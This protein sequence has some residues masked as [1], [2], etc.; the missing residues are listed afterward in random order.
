MTTAPTTMTTAPITSDLDRVLFEEAPVGLA[1]LDR[2]LR[3]VRVNRRLAD[4]NGRTVEEMLGRRVSDVFPDVSE[5]VLDAFERVLQTGAVIEGLEVETLRGDPPRG[6]TFVAGYRPVAD[7]DEIIGVAVSSIEITAQK[8]AEDEARRSRDVADLLAAL[9]ASLAAATS[10]V[11]AARHVVD[12]TGPAFGAMTAGFFLLDA[13]S[14]LRSIA[15]RGYGDGILAGSGAWPH[16]APSPGAAAMRAG[17]LLAWPTLEAVEADFPEIAAAMRERTGERAVASVPLLVD[18]E[19][20]GALHVGFDARRELSREE[21]G[22]LRAIADVTAQAIRRI[23]LTDAERRS[24]RVLEAV[25]DQMPLG[26]ILAGAHGELAIMNAESR[27][28]WGGFQPASSVFDQAG[29]RAFHPDGT[30]YEPEDWPLARS[31]TTGEVITD[32]DIEIETF[33]GRRRVLE[34]AS[35]PIRDDDGSILGAVVVFTDVTEKREASALRDAFIGMLSHELRT[36]ITSIY[37]VANLLEA[38]GATMDPETRSGL[39]EDMRAESDRLFRLVE[40]LLVLARAER[41]VTT[42]DA[43][44]VLVHRLIPRIVESEAA[45]WPALRIRFT[46]PD[47]LPPA[48]ADEGFVDLIL[49]NLIG[50][51]AKYAPGPVE[52]RAEHVDGEIH[53]DVCDAGVGIPESEL[54]HVFELFRRVARPG[55]PAVP[56]SGIGLYVVRHLAEAMGGRA[57]ARNRPEGGADVG[58]SLPVDPEV[59]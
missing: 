24:R 16:E 37:G 36:P 35:A 13:E 31:L 30:P 14:T 59:A 52:V 27:R 1:F 45:A 57:W 41:G 43:V 51:A 46:V 26:V 54:D 55:R 5:A 40:N 7:G 25:I 48:R 2:D 3:F 12:A 42:I 44:P 58:F 22:D 32:E 10:I 23:R 8:R 9:N 34:D 15:N 18:G 11:D 17:E 28:I 47:H 21:I 38:R 50:N 56:G 19:P 33:D 39:L 53:V 4:L 29:Y 49:R 6:R 20:I